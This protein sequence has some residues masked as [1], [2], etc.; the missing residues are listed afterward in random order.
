MSPPANYSLA[1]L[2]MCARFAAK[3]A[4]ND[5]YTSRLRDACTLIRIKKKY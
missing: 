2:F 4:V 5:I 3:K 1:K